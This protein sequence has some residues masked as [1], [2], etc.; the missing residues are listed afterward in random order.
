MNPVGEDTD[1]VQRLVVRL[2][3]LVVGEHLV[4]T[5]LVL[6]FLGAVGELERGKGLGRVEGRR[7]ARAEQRRHGVAPE[8]ILQEPGQLGIAVGDVQRLPVRELVDDVAEE[9]Q[10]EVDVL[11]LLEALPC[12]TGLVDPLRA[13]EVDEEEL[14]CRLGAALRVV[15]L[16][17]EELH[18]GVRPRARLVRLCSRGVLPARSPRYHVEGLRGVLNRHA[19]Q[20]LDVDAAPGRAVLANSQQVPSA[21]VLR[22]AVDA[23]R[24]VGGPEVEELLVVQL[25]HRQLHRPRDLRCVKLLQPR[26]QVV[27]HAGHDAALVRGQQLGRAAAGAEHRVGLAAARLPVREDRSVVAVEHGVDRG[28]ADRGVDVVLG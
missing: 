24:A 2:A 9:G 17:H 4:R 20:P 13:C 8:G 7:G 14:R 18:N 11:G 1:L 23:R 15:R 3:Q 26:Q 22:R 28:L 12:G 5:R 21:A 25:Q 10:R 6:D 27:K 16:R 19:P